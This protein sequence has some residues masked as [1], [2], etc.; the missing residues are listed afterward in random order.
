MNK[1]PDPRAID[2]T[3]VREGLRDVAYMTIGLGVVAVE[4]L[5]SARKRFTEKASARF[6]ELDQR[7]DLLET[8]IETAV[9][10]FETKLPEQAGQL[11]DQARHITRVARQQVRDRIRPAA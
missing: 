6:A 9:D 7:I 2:F 11:V 8:R 1:I 3:P 10:T 5:Q 4:E